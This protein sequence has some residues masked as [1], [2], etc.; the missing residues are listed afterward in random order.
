MPSQQRCCHGVMRM[1]HCASRL[2]YACSEGAQLLFAS[3]QHLTPTLLKPNTIHLH[4]GLQA[5]ARN[6]LT[7]S[8][9]CM[10]A[11]TATESFSGLCCFAARSR[12]LPAWRAPSTTVRR[13][14]I[15][16]HVHEQPY[17]SYGLM[18]GHANY[19]TKRQMLKDH[20]P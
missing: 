14:Q 18:P 13:R 2:I 19:N 17:A 20:T 4:P 5:A 6:I 1:M 11:A 3:V 7:L 9:L 12:K 8:S 10:S 16:W 15:G